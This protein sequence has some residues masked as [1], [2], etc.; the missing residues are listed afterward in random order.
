MRTREIDTSRA[1]YKAGGGAAAGFM[2]AAVT[3]SRLASPF[4]KSGPTILS[5]SMN[6]VNAFAM[7]LS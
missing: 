6:R 5:M 4:S 3:A 7:K 2:A 1:I